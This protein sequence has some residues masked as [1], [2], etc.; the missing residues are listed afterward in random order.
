MIAASTMEEMRPNT[1]TTSWRRTIETTVCTRCCFARLWLWRRDPMNVVSWL[2]L[3]E[4]VG[5]NVPNAWIE[6]LQNDNSS[7]PCC[8][9]LLKPFP[10]SAQLWLRMTCIRKCVRK[11]YLFRFQKLVFH[12]RCSSNYYDY[13]ISLFLNFQIN[14]FESISWS[15]M[16]TSLR[17]L[18]LRCDDIVNSTFTVKK[19]WNECKR[20]GWNVW[21]CPSPNERRRVAGF[22]VVSCIT[23]RACVATTSG[24]VFYHSVW[25]LNEAENQSKLFNMTV[26]NNL[27]LRQEVWRRYL[28]IP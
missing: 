14:T 17:Q 22:L 3:Q 6:S 28:Q 1:P 24:C 25:Y 27:I 12:S 9:L 16:S 8:D 18:L 23:W 19:G 20:I 21:L 7:V 4:R 10:S 26:V 13:G 2:N 5:G 11:C 15:Y